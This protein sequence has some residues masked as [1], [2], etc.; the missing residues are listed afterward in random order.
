MKWS[1]IIIL[2]VYFLNILID[3]P[4]NKTF[5]IVAIELA[6]Q[7]EPSLNNIYFNDKRVA[8][9]SGLIAFDSIDLSTAIDVIKYPILVIKYGRFEKVL[10]IPN[11]K[12]LHYVPSKDNPRLIIYQR[13]TN[14]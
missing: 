5:D 2:L 1:L 4:K 13:E 11:Y 7:E 3:N 9:Y 12:V 10:T 8:F 6:M 14:D